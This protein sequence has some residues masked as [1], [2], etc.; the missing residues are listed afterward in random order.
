MKNSKFVKVA[1]T[2]L[3]IVTLGSNTA[4]AMPINV[5]NKQNT[6]KVYVLKKSNLNVGIGNIQVSKIA[7]NI[8]SNT[9]YQPSL[10]VP[11]TGNIAT[12]G[13]IITYKIPI[14]FTSTTSKKYDIKDFTVNVNPTAKYMTSSNS[15][16]EENVEKQIV[17][18][19]Q[20]Q[21]STVGTL[22]TGS[23]VI[24]TVAL[25]I[26]QADWDMDLNPNISI[27]YKCNG[28]NGT[29]NID[30]AP[31]KLTNKY[32]ENVV[33]STNIIEGK[34]KNNYNFNIGFQ[35][36]YHQLN[37]PGI[38]NP[39]NLKIKSI[40][41]KI[42]N[43]SSNE[44][45][46]IPNLNK[47]FTYD[48]S[49]GEYTITGDYLNQNN[50]NTLFDL[51]TLNNGLIYQNITIKPT[52]IQYEDM[53]NVAFTTNIDYQEGV[54]PL[55]Q[56]A[57]NH[58]GINADITQISQYNQN[59]YDPTNTY[60][61][62]IKAGL[63]G[64]YNVYSGSIINNGQAIAI[65]NGQLEIKPGQTFV[66]LNQAD[67]Y[68]MNNGTVEQKEVLMQKIVSG[69]LDSN[70]GEYSYNDIKNNLGKIALK[71]INF[72]YSSGKYIGETV[73]V[74]GNY[75]VITFKKEDE[76]ASYFISKTI[77][78]ALLDGNTT[79]E[80][81]KT[82]DDQLSN[83]IDK[84]TDGI[85]T[86]DRKVSG[87]L[88]SDNNQVNL[89]YVKNHPNEFPN[90][91]GQTT[92]ERFNDISHNVSTMNMAF[93]S[94]IQI[95]ID[96]NNT[97]NRVRLGD[98]ISDNHN[99][100]IELSYY[101]PGITM[102][103]TKNTKVKIDMGCPFSLSG[104]IK[105]GGV[106]L[107][108]NQYQIDGNNL[109][110]TAPKAMSADSSIEFNIH[111]ENF[112]PEATINISAQYDGNA[113]D[114]SGRVVKI[115]GNNEPESHINNPGRI[116]TSS[117]ITVINTQLNNCQSYYTPV[118]SNNI[119]TITNIIHNACTNIKTYLVIGD[120]PQENSN[121][122]SGNLGFPSIGNL[123]SNYVNGTLNT[124]GVQTWVLPKVNLD[125]GI[126]QE[127]ISDANGYKMKDKLAYIENPSN[128]WILYKA[129]L[130]TGNIVA[131]AATPTLS[132][133]QNFVANYNAQLGNIKIGAYQYVTTAFKYYDMTNNLANTSN[134]NIIPPA[135]ENLDNKWIS[136]VVR[137]DNI[138]LSSS[139]LD[140]KVSVN[141]K[142]YSLRELIGSGNNNDGKKDLTPNTP[143]DNLMG[144][145][146][147]ALDAP[148]LN[149]LGYQLDYIDINGAKISNPASWFKET[150]ILNNTKITTIKFVISKVTTDTVKV[151][152]I[153][154]P[155]KPVEFKDLA[156][157]V[158]GEPNISTEF[159]SLKIPAGYHIVKVMVNAKEVP[160]T[161]T[162]PTEFTNENTNTIYY[163][164]KNKNK[165][166]VSEV[167]ANGGAVVPSKTT[168]VIDGTNITTLTG[169]P[170]IVE[171]YHVTEILL[172]GKMVKTNELPEIM[173]T[174]G[175]TIQYVIGKN[176]VD[177]VKV[178]NITDPTKP[179]EFKNL[180]QS[181]TGVPDSKTGLKSLVIPADYHLVK[182]TVNGKEVA[183]NTGV[184]AD[185]TNS[186]VNTIYYVAKNQDQLT[187][188]EV[189]ANGG[190]VFPSKTTSV[191]DGTNI[192]SLTGLPKVIEGY[193]IEKI[194]LNGKEVTASDLPKVM[195]LKATTIQYVIAKNPVDTVKI[196][197]IT[198]PNDPIEDG[199]PQV[200]EGMPGSK[201]GLLNPT[202]PSGYH[203]VEV[204]VNDKKVDENTKVPT[205]FTNQNTTV[206]YYI[207][208][209]KDV[210]PI[211][212]DNNKI[213]N[214]N[215]TNKDNTNN[216]NNSNIINNK[217][218]N[219]TN[220]NNKT[221][222]I[223]P[224]KADN[225]NVQE[226][227]DT[228]L[229]VHDNNFKNDIYYIFALLGS[230]ILFIFRK[231]K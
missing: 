138:K 91:V 213:P 148:I 10:A 34:D 203:L 126:N 194:L 196:I 38:Y 145:V 116:V 45:Q 37:Q 87:F 150:G 5:G 35:E 211:N 81:N 152:N 57:S 158:T 225:S 206:I 193:H 19:I 111:Y 139:D 63:V 212:P 160:N 93:A 219:D 121:T 170:K 189:Y 18:S 95:S 79:D 36:I 188:S 92:N 205:V 129:G 186:D 122:L 161:T 226:L 29:S 4:Y 62:T 192:E 11:S 221:N 73:N 191:I 85:I 71:T 140:K 120:I 89:N 127:L 58:I 197:D 84:N 96:N 39:A 51:K 3:A 21:I 24:V 100:K 147:M 54:A 187:V 199:M 155:T 1:I 102:D 215:N 154:D 132:P 214:T 68:I 66:S 46:V 72:V 78:L 64:N 118:N 88:L 179:V 173:P 169:L 146:N 112:N 183:N 6:K 142:E 224:A 56:K 123:S 166:T 200:V 136:T 60:G 48:K 67:M 69:K 33:T 128:G 20:K 143:V 130:E 49:T 184:P 229:N 216:N 115:N 28:V 131:Y 9:I 159:N 97:Q 176:A 80:Q 15:L 47:D 113:N 90:G 13:T 125:K 74:G 144:K 207:V 117:K 77:T 44:I 65:N 70:E 185:F 135:E 105:F 222:E 202:I 98:W 7:N 133:G 180:A 14:S 223:K 204:T 30:V 181:V 50:L 151:F 52:N 8:T 42:Q 217:T 55:E 31:I 23:T 157:T 40:S 228:G 156:Q 208:K 209:N 107:N 43:P 137:E 231:K 162:L 94:S 124:Q 32:S 177:T 75:S 190:A 171:E 101:Y 2:S 25:A 174:T 167:Y 104:P 182:V 168:S 41:F 153:T 82:I 76:K 103:L 163:V 22:S 17:Q 227:P 172:N 175:V 12:A 165:L 218:E 109:I 141:G 59:W 119:T 210:S 201:T 220:N 53:K 83:G 26:N 27:S 99:I 106:V 134:I 178:M 110:V 114:P 198:N 16:N 230:M 195:P 86:K 149:K 108:K 61:T 164:A